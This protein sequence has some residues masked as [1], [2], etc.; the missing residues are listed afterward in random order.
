MSGMGDTLN[1]AIELGK[2]AVAL[3][4]EG[5]HE[6]AAKHYEEAAAVLERLSA[7]NLNVPQTLNSKAAEY[8]QRAAALRKSSKAFLHT[9]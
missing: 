4:Q 3:D 6:G 5:K 2:I 9:S 8:R 1:S 7:L